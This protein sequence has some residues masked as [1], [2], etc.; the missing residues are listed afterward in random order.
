MV[1]IRAKRH[2][3]VSRSYH[4][5]TPHLPIYRRFCVARVQSNQ[6]RPDRGPSQHHSPRDLAR[7]SRVS[8]PS[9]VR[10][11][12]RH[13]HL[14]TFY[15]GHANC[16]WTRVLPHSNTCGHGEPKQ[17]YQTIFKTFPSS[18]E[19]A[20][21]NPVGFFFALSPKI[22]LLLLCLIYFNSL[23]QINVSLPWIL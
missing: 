16:S 14:P 1:R 12:V 13:A 20:T 7:T 21:Q 9:F 18:T 15:L 3:R 11:H 6:T 5:Y 2:T 17:K 22:L 4:I 10:W 23:V 19:L 8:R